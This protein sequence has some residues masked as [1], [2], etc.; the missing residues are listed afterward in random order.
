MGIPNDYNNDNYKNSVPSKV[1]KSMLPVTKAQL[2]SKECVGGNMAAASL[3]GIVAAK[4][5]KKVSWNL[6][7]LADYVGDMQIC[8]KLRVGSDTTC[9]KRGPDMQNLCVVLLTHTNSYTKSP[10][11]HASA[12][13]EQYPVRYHCS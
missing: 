1:P 6:N 4:S 3:L 10:H 2:A 13:E 7:G 9:E 8:P 11:H 5:N 12:T